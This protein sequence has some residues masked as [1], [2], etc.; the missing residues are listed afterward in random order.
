[1]SCYSSQVNRR[2]PERHTQLHY[3]PLSTH[4]SAVSDIDDDV[5]LLV[6]ESVV[7]RREVR[8]VVGVAAVRLDDGERHRMTRDEDDLTTLVQLHVPWG[9][10]EKMVLRERNNTGMIGGERGDDE[11]SEEWRKCKKK[12]KKWKRIEGKEE[13]ITPKKTGEDWKRFMGRYCPLV[14]RFRNTWLQLK[15]VSWGPKML[16]QNLQQP[17]YDFMLKW[18]KNES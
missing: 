2:L 16:Q 14:V 18:M 8:R 10:G 9:G 1:M 4:L 12:K 7:Q 6:E 13:E 17:D 11:L 15:R 5:S 3:T